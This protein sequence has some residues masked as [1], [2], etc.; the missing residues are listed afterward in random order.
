[1]SVLHSPS[2]HAPMIISTRCGTTASTL[3]FFGLP[4]HVCMHYVPLVVL[5]CLQMLVTLIH[6]CV[7]SD[8]SQ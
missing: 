6:T 4:C 2:H 1:M 5:A 8:P 3:I 7:G